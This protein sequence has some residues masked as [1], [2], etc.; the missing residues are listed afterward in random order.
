ME[1]LTYRIES[2]YPIAGPLVPHPHV[3][4]IVLHNRSLAVVAAAKSVTVPYGHEIRVIHIQ[5]GEVIFRK[6]AAFAV[7]DISDLV[8]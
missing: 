4:G 8:S 6:T 5:T 2:L 7:S 3:T 1:T